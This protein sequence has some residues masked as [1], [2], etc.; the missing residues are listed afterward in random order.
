MLSRLGD[1]HETGNSLINLKERANRKEF[2]HFFPESMHI[3]NGRDLS[4]GIEN[5]RYRAEKHIHT[6]KAL[7]IFHELA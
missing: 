6:A 3:Q 4:R 2:N 1:I 7:D 5:V